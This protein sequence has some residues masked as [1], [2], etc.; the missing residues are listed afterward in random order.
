MIPSATVNQI[1]ARRSWSRLAAMRIFTAATITA[2]STMA[3]IQK[4]GPSHFCAAQGKIDML[5]TTV[6]TAVRHRQIE[7]RHCSTAQ[8]ARRIGSPWWKRARMNKVP[9]ERH[10]DHRGDA[11]PDAE[12]RDEAQ[13]AADIGRHGAGIMRHRKTL[14]HRAQR[15]AAEEGHHQAGDPEGP[16]PKSVASAARPD[17][18]IPVPRRG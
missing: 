6:I 18:G 5:N 10:R 15:H 1:S 17:A 14:H 12:G 2:S 4:F 13:G 7:N 16:D 9:A 11:G 8:P 3:Q